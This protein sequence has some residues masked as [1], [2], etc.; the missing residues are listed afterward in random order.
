[1][2]IAGLAVSLAAQDSI[3]NLFGSITVL[4]SRPFGLGDRIV[5]G[6]Y[7]GTVENISFRDTKIRTV[8]GHLVTV[9]NMKFT[10][11]TVENI[12]ARPFIA[13]T[14]DIGLTHDTPPDRV[15]EALRIIRGIL[16]EPEFAEEMKVPDRDPRAYFKDFGPAGPVAR[17]RLVRRRPAWVARRR[18]ATT[19]VATR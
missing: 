17:R 15:E 11:G 12:S 5:F 14:I 8:G 3:K 6:A 1:M 10:D 7:D 19:S 13:R 16:S 9:P 18:T 2:G 4:V